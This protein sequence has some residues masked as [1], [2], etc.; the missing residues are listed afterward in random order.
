MSDG[1]HRDGESP[2]GEVVYGLR[3]QGDERFFHIGSGSERR[4]HDLNHRS[5]AV[6]SFIETRGGDARVEVV[7][8]ER[9]RCPARARLREM[10]LVGRHQPETN[11]FGRSSIP[12]GILHGRPKRS[13]VRCSC[14]APDCYGAE[15][16]ARSR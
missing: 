11:T 9:H 12:A 16:D 1:H 5:P 8:L 3:M 13:K 4:A 7:I 6:R 14:G 2:G 10:E 15:V